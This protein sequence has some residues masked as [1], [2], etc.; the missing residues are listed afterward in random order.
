L[1]TNQDDVPDDI[2][3]IP[4]VFKLMTRDA[5]M[6]KKRNTTNVAIESPEPALAR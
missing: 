1:L 2:K 4:D 5:K 6:A 3:A